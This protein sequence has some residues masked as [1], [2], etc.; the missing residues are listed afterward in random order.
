M[1]SI[2]SINLC[3]AN[4]PMLISILWNL[5]HIGNKN[6]CFPYNYLYLCIQSDQRYLLHNPHILRFSLMVQKKIKQHLQLF[7]HP[8]FPYGTSIYTA[9]LLAIRVALQYISKYSIKASIIFT[10]SLSA[11]QSLESPTLHQSAILSILT[12][13]DHLHTPCPK[14]HVTTFS[15]ITLTISVRLQ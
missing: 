11:L 15:T 12:I 10:D 1:R 4:Q 14:K 5:L 2:L 3:I 13:I 8:K 7:S 9:E 6:N